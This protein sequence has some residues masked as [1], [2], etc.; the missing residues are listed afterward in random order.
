M[1]KIKFSEEIC[2]GVLSEAAE[3]FEDEALQSFI[4]CQL[5]YLCALLFLLAV[6]KI[7]ITKQMKKP[8]LCITL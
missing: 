4:F 3:S 8:K 1:A 6:C 7:Y 5:V 2:D